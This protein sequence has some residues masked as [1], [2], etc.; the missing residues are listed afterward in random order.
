[1]FL[2]IE[3]PNQP[4]PIVGSDQLID[5]IDRVTIRNGSELRNTQTTVFN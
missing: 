2:D 3:K 1:M 5:L 4:S